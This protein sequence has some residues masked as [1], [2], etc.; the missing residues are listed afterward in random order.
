MP[1]K[2]KCFLSTTRTIRC[3]SSGTAKDSNKRYDYRKDLYEADCLESS[4]EAKEKLD[5]LG[6]GRYSRISYIPNATNIL[7][8]RYFCK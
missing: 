6:S 4:K 3:D 5:G 8:C 7:K 1:F 2:T